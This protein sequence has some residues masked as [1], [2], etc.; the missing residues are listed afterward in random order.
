MEYLDATNLIHLKGRA[1]STIN[2]GVQYVDMSNVQFITSSDIAELITLVKSGF[3]QGT[4]V[5]LI[6][7]RENVRN[8]I[9]K[10]ELDNILCC[11]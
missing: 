10:L 2:D 3:G 6:N 11:E 1:V 5:R 9:N 8:F 7:V 4:D